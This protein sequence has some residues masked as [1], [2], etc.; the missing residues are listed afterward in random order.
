MFLLFHWGRYCGGCTESGHSVVCSSRPQDVPGDP[1]E[2]TVHQTEDISGAQTK[3]SLSRCF[4][5][6][7]QTAPFPLAYRILQPADLLYRI[8]PGKAEKARKER[9]GK[10]NLVL[11]RS[12]THWMLHTAHLFLHRT[13][14]RP[15]WRTSI[16]SQIILSR[17]CRQRD[18]NIH[19][20]QL[21]QS[22][23][24]QWPNSKVLH[25]LEA[26]MKS[27]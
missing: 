4:L 18:E 15:L 13:A 16:R 20:D 1:A 22:F 8:I 11:G 21:R 19:F 25:H 24:S 27:I 17:I 3:F 23:N 2:S 7:T 6:T 9:Y 5:G 10:I 14:Q 26:F 12:S